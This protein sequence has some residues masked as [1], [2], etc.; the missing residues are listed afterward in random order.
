M[1]WYDNIFLAPPEDEPEQVLDDAVYGILHDD[2]DYEVEV[3]N[4][5]ID[6]I[7]RYEEDGVTRVEC[8][9]EISSTEYYALIVEKVEELDKNEKLANN[10]RD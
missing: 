8:F 3:N 6:K 7:Y 9:K 5:Q 4:G 1:S 10:W 2:I